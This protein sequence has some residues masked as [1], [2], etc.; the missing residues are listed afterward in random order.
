MGW[1]KKKKKKD[2]CDSKES[3]ESSTDDSKS[4][5][6]NSSVYEKKK[7]KKSKKD[8]YALTVTKGE[9]RKNDK[10]VTIC[11]YCGKTGHGKATCWALHGKPDKKKDDNDH[12]NTECWLCRKKGHTVR[13]CP[14][15]KKFVSDG[16]DAEVE[17]NT[18]FHTRRPITSLCD[19]QRDYHD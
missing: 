13:F 10:G 18:Y 19:S 14:N 17:I 7:K 9:D 1:D 2:V 16:K 4:S 12:S 8:K 15:K 6:S 5:S 11:G 3:D